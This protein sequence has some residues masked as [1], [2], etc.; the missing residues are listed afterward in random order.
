VEVL[1]ATF[2]GGTPI[3]TIGPYRMVKK[4]AFTP[5]YPLV[6]DTFRPAVTAAFSPGVR[7]QEIVSM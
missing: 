1:T 4:S 5:N 3:I 2:T 7:S 6:S